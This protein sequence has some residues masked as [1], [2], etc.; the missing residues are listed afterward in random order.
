MRL[1][2]LVY[3]NLCALVGHFFLKQPVYSVFPP[4][5]EPILAHFA[6]RLSSFPFNRHTSPLDRY[7]EQ[8]A[9]QLATGWQRAWSGVGLVAAVD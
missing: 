3:V 2:E 7:L 1:S 4:K 5:N 8:A 6:E 9:R